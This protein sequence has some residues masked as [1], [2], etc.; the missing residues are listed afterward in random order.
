MHF[1]NFIF[2]IKPVICWPSSG[3]YPDTLIS[4]LLFPECPKLLIAIEI[5]LCLLFSPVFIPSLGHYCW[6]SQVLVS[7]FCWQLPNL[8]FYL[9]PLT[10]SWLSL[11][12]AWLPSWHF[13]SEL[14]PSNFLQLSCSLKSCISIT[15]ISVFLF[16]HWLWCMQKNLSL[17]LLRSVSNINKLL[18]FHHGSLNSN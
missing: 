7:H 1:L 16:F 9:Y 17:F 10:L 6:C 11:C 8:F 5:S 14:M 12:C 2:F 13:W 3:S 18:A 15:F 4:V